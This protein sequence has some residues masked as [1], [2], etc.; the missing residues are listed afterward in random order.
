METINREIDKLATIEKMIDEVK[1]SGFGEVLITINDGKI[2][3][4]RKTEATKWSVNIGENKV[5][6]TK[7]GL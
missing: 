6:L 4:C 5:L 2:A 3:Y 1:Q 7:I